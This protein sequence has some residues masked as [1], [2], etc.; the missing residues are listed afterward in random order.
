M[1]IKISD[2]HIGNRIRR[3][4]GDL[5]ALMESMKRFGLLQPILIDSNS[6]L[7]AGYRRLLAARRLGWEFIDVRMI[8]AGGKKELLLIEA[9]ENTTRRDFTPIEMERA[10]RLLR[11]YSKTGILGRLLAW[12]LDLWDRFFYRPPS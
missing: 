12:F 9:D 3:D 2:I 5:S 10:Q 8:E 4:G 7:I 6:K 1:K 11:R